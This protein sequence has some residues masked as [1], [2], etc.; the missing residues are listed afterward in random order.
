M[1]RGRKK[2]V[3][4]EVV[5]SIGESVDKVSDEQIFKE[6]VESIE[7]PVVVP[8]LYDGRVVLEVKGVQIGKRL[9]RDYLFVD[10]TQTRVVA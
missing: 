6:V 1:P 8:E 3:V 7:I 2:K 9:Y 4:E 5:E 10:G